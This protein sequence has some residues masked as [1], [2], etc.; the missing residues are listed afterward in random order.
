MNFFSTN[1]KDF[2]YILFSGGLVVCRIAKFLISST[3]LRS[4]FF[5]SVL[6]ISMI[7]SLAFR[8]SSSCSRK[9]PPYLISKPKSLVSPLI[10]AACTGVLPLLQCLQKKFIMLL[11]N[12][13]ILVKYQHFG[14]L[15]LLLLEDLKINHV[16]FFLQNYIIELIS[17][18]DKF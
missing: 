14:S 10:I 9:S 11:Q 17:I 13:V 6:S 5:K 8:P 2:I 12:K 18:V 3:Y 16:V 7:K 1:I 4:F 15:C